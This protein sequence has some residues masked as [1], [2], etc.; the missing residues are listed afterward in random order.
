[1]HLLAIVAA[2]IVFHFQNYDQNTPVAP[3]NSQKCNVF[4]FP[5]K[6]QISVLLHG[7]SF[8]VK[9]QIAAASHNSYIAAAATFN[10]LQRKKGSQIPVLL[11]LVIDAATFFHFPATIGQTPV[12]LL[13]PRD[14][15]CS[16]VFFRFQ[17]LRA[18][19]HSL[20]C[21]GGRRRR[22]RSPRTPDQARNP[23]KGREATL[24]LRCFPALLSWHS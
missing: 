16:N 23:A 9:R 13:A 19:P 22:R 17:T 3:S 1:M 4:S 2:Y 6:R 15:S 14:N 18:I 8:S 11:L 10:I 7:V 5:A 21:C 20:H 12:L 24:R